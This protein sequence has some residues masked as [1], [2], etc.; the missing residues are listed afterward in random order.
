MI[1]R[2]PTTRRTPSAAA[3]ILIV[4]AGILAG[5]LYKVMA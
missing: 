2:I 5:Y 4:A 3:C 1:Q